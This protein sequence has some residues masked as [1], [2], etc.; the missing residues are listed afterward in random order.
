VVLRKGNETPRFDE[1]FYG[2][3]KNKARAWPF[4]K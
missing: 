3:G 2:Y 1:R 4:T